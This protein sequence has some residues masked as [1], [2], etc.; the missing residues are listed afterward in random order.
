MRV[1]GLACFAKI[2][3]IATGAPVLLASR[4]VV[5]A[6]TNKSTVKLLVCHGNA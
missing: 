6:G 3:V 1:V 4:P 2:P 5:S